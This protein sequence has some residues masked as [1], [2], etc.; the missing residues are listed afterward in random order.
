MI[1][2]IT[3]KMWEL[4]ACGAG[5]ALAALSIYV[6]ILTHERDAALRERAELAAEYAQF[7]LK[8]AEVISQRLLQNAKDAKALE[9]ATLTAMDNYRKGKIDAQKSYA[10]ANARI[11]QLRIPTQ[12]HT[13]TDSGTL[14]DYGS[15]TEGTTVSC[16]QRLRNA[17]EQFNEVVRSVEEVSSALKAAKEEALTLKALVGY[18]KARDWPK[19]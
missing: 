4:L 3:G 14:P 5:I 8:S 12:D 10:A 7:Q 18:E 15:P 6:A 16:E 1:S 9:D 13:S 11:E 2:W 17:A 19:P